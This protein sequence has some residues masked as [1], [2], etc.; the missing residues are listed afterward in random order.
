[1]HTDDNRIRWDRLPK[2]S[3]NKHARAWLRLQCLLGLA[4]NT[5]ASYGR[6]L[7]EFLT[8]CDQHACNA[9]ELD[10]VGVARY[11]K[12]AET[13][14]TRPLSN[15]SLLLRQTVLR[16]FFDY[17]V[18]E[19]V[20]TS[21]PVGRNRRI[22]ERTS[23]RPAPVR[24]LERLPWIPSDADWLQFLAEC[25]K[26]TLR[27]RC[28]VALA[29]DC[30]LRREELCKL[31]ARDFDP[32]HRTVRVRAETS[33]SRRDRVV[34]YSAT[35]GSLY[36]SYLRDRRVLAGRSGAVFLSES[37]R[38]LG[39]PITR[40]TWSKVVRRIALGAGLPEFSTHTL[41]H[42]C[43]TDLA[44]AGWGIHEIA[45]FAGH[46]NVSVTQRYI[47]LSGRDL[48]DKL[49]RSAASVRSSRILP[50]EVL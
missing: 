39:Q 16:L 2:T 1:M 42:L 22:W 41:R 25:R 49:A 17:L 36:A 5:I 24:R 35:A 47:H 32:A 45:T 26:H 50:L 12:D 46:R 14:R 29:Y 20:R 38:N 18:E 4:L 27:T 8:W 6:A 15:A 31:E 21:N 9:V 34:I 44:R 3:S 19:G 37:R 11:L 40:W 48:A 30:G 13:R 33:K 10:R 23:W 43:L 7:E 28:M